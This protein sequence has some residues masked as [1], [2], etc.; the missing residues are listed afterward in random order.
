VEFTRHRMQRKD[1]GFHF[2]SGSGTRGRSSVRFQLAGSF[3]PNV[4]PGTS[5]EGR[6]V[7]IRLVRIN[8]LPK[9]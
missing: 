5:M 2:D 7:T 3:A 1:E 9:Q 6:V 8:F 4:L